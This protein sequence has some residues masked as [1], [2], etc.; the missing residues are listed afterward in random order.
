MLRSLLAR[1]KSPPSRRAFCILFFVPW[2]LILAIPTLRWQLRVQAIGSEYADGNFCFPVALPAIWLADRNYA[3]T[4]KQLQNQAKN[5]E[6]WRAAIDLKA[7]RQRGESEIEPKEIYRVSG[8]ALKTQPRNVYLLSVRLRAALYFVKSARFAKDS[9][10]FKKMSG[11]KQSP[12][13]SV[14]DE[15]WRDVNYDRDS[16]NFNA[17][18]RD[19]RREADDFNASIDSSA[20]GDISKIKW[21]SAPGVALQA[22]Q[23][24]GALEP[25][26]AYW[27]WQESYLLLVFQR[28]AQAEKALKRAAQL[29]K[30]D[31]HRNDDLRQTLLVAQAKR[32]LFIEEKLALN[33]RVSSTDN[34]FP[35][36]EKLWL[37]QVMFA[38]REGDS[39]RSLALSGALANI[40]AL[41]LQNARDNNAKRRA[42]LLQCAAWRGEKRKPLQ[43]AAGKGQKAVYYDLIELNFLS[44]AGYGYA[45]PRRAT[46]DMFARRF[47]Q[48]ARQAGQSDLAKVA[49]QQGQESNAIA[50][51]VLRAGYSRLGNVNLANL[52][53][54]PALLI[55]K[56]AAQMTLV[57]WQITLA[58]WCALHIVLWRRL[59]FIGRWAARIW[60]FVGM[61][62]RTRDKP[63]WDEDV[64]LLQQEKRDGARSFWFA[65]AFA[66][67]TAFGISY[68]NVPFAEWYPEVFRDYYNQASHIIPAIASLLLYPI[69]PVL[70][71][72]LWCG[73]A[74]LRRFYRLQLPRIWRD[75]IETTALHAPPSMIPLASAFMTWSLTVFALLCWLGGLLAHY[76]PRG[77][78]DFS[79]PPLWASLLETPTISLFSRWEEW[80]A[81]A[82]MASVVALVAWVWKW[83]WQMHSRR[84][85]PALYFGLSW[86]RQTL[87]A[88]LILASWLYLILLVLA[89]PPRREAD[90]QFSQM[91]NS[92][93]RSDYK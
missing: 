48:S 56:W 4:W 5:S 42:L 13:N 67:P 40:A 31:D 68:W 20:T 34:A 49:L 26:N 21:Q 66:V 65:A 73:G 38:E 1:F 35:Q 29:L 91:I 90:A 15:I 81:L 87:G 19:L 57:Q 28:D 14:F 61:L 12:R 8:E 58:F 75:D 53:S 32:P 50:R 88:W 11:Q 23:R 71:S 74:A 41:Q 16:R 2:L 45:S 59:W 3:P 60:Q 72:F 93:Q 33:T 82:A 22:A 44:Y 70:F 47:A 54:L 76:L 30:F 17:A 27:P 85:L 18:G 43:R 84:R 24:G 78:F 25:D 79:L 36:R 39:K 7:P 51:A 69:A 89:L 55:F 46:P 83:G 77:S 9:A 63:L 6:Q 92:T 86:W 80:A 37:W 64:P 62:W 10:R 52:P